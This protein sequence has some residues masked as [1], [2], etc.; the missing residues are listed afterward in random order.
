MGSLASPDTA[1]SP[2]GDCPLHQSQQEAG[3]NQDIEG[4]PLRRQQGPG[5]DEGEASSLITIE[6]R[7][8]ALEILKP[9]THSLSLP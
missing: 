4:R 1:W 9:F 5:A 2:A 6:Q 3:G 7:V 8:P